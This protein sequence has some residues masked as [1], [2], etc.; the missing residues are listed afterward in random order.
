MTFLSY[1]QNFE[2]VMLWRALRTV[3]RGFYIDVGA[4]HPD[5]DSVTRAF[6]DR[7]WSGINVEPVADS[8]KRL[9]AARVRDTTLQVAVGEAPGS[10][11]FFVVEGTGLSTLRRNG[12]AEFEKL[13]FVADP[14]NVEV[15]TLADICRAHAPA[16]IHFLKIDVEGTEAAV[17]SGAD[18]ATFR[19][20]IVLAEATAPMTT[21]DTS[22]AWEPILLRA[23]YQFVYFDGLNRFYIA[24]ERHE[25]LSPSFRVPPNVFDDF[26]RIADTEW[27]RRIADA[28]ARVTAFDAVSREAARA[29]ARAR[30]LQQAIESLQ[31]SAAAGLRSIEAAREAACNEAHVAA[32][33]LAAMRTSTSWRITAP[34]RLLMSTASAAVRRARPAPSPAE[35]AAS[36]DHAPAARPTSAAA[37]VETVETAVQIRTV[38][39]PQ[40][41]PGPRRRAV[42]QFHSGSA[43]GDAITN[44]ML[45]TRTLL[46]QQ[47]YVS[48]IFV[49]HVDSLLADE[50]RPMDELPIHTDY[51]LILRHSIGYDA[52]DRII[53]LPGD[54]LKIGGHAAIAIG[55]DESLAGW[56]F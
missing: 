15:T 21:Q 47:G 31:A 2:D 53:A 34:L 30:A 50:L 54:W 35:P 55:G 44:A 23:G 10:A 9:R 24:D 37:P 48:E 51:V 28:Q 6:Y 27:T 13:G 7:G 3:E 1:A 29:N 56:N 36:P 42:H 33:A 52:F 39:S 32:V 18:F 45:L 5:A 25:E 12:L 26:L 8:A 20:W 40:A 43:T 19:P 17:L 22:G 11:E 16:D 14:T 38:P 41:A 4:A 49:E 46:R